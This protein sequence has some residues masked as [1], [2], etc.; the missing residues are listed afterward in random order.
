MEDRSIISCKM[1]NIQS[2]DFRMYTQYIWKKAL[3]NYENKRYCLN[4][5]YSLPFGHP[6]INKIETEEMSNEEVINNLRGEDGYEIKNLSNTHN[7]DDISSLQINNIAASVN[8]KSEYKTIL[9]N[10]NALIKL[11]ECSKYKAEE[12]LEELF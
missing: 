8:F 5:L 7:N 3:I 6:W 1:Q 9:S 10:P 11:K 4:S 12:E 2:K